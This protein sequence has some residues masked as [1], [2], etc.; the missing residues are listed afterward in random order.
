MEVCRRRV[1]VTDAFESEEVMTE[2]MAMKQPLPSAAPPPS[3]LLPM[4]MMMKMMM[5]ATCN[6]SPLL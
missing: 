1:F 6:E 2:V 3:Q 4:M 5:S